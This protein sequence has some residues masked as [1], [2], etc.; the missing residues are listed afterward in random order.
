MAKFRMSAAEGVAITQIPSCSKHA[1][2]S[3]RAQ[4]EISSSS[5]WSD[6]TPKGLCKELASSVRLTK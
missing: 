5:L 1:L 3:P 2:N 6:I 4:A